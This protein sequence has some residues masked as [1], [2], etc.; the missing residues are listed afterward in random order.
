MLPPDTYAAAAI[1]S[2]DAHENAELLRRE[3]IDVRSRLGL[4]ERYQAA[5][6]TIEL[7]ERAC[8]RLE[9]VADAPLLPAD[10]DARLND[11]REKRQI[12]RQKLSDLAAARDDIERQLRDE[13][14]PE[15]VLAEEA[16]IEELKK[17]VGADAKQQS[18]ALKA[19]AR[20]SE[21][22]A[23]ARDIFRE[24]T[25]STE[26]DR[27]TGFKL[28]LDHEQRITQLANE[29]KAVSEDVTHNRRA[30][31]LARAVLADAKRK[32]ASADATIDTV[33]WLAAVEAIAAIGPLEQNARTRKSEVA[34]EE[35]KL[36]AEF[37]RFQ[38]PAPELGLAPQRSPFRCQKP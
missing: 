5:L 16:E 13:Q 17:L 21:E 28:R 29:Q 31:Q 2:R 30:V 35:L 37:A 4:L 26:W 18:E 6:P 3:R 32:Q 11:A 10:F 9:P 34:S 14:P 8:K 19:G 36:A 22:E 24:L 7:L 12:A 38:P 20:R 15:A 25:G 33:P 1:K 23:K 27:M